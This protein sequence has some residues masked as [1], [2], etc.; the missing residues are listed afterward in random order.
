MGGTFQ[1]TA[2]FQDLDNFPKA[3][4]IALTCFLSMN[5]DLTGFKL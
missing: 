4:K 3:M 1:T 5:S 2:G